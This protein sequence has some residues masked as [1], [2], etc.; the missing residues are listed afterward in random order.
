MGLEKTCE[1]RHGGKV[2]TAQAHLEPAELVLR[3]ALKLKIPAGDI[4]SAE[5]RAGVLHVKWRGGVVDL[6]LGRDAEK[7]ALKIRYPRGRLDKLGIKPQMRV[8][9][10]GL[11]DAEFLAE[12]RERTSDVKVGRPAKDTD[13]ILVALAKSAD[14]PKLKTLRASLKK[15]GMIWAVWTKGRKE[16][17]EDDVRAYGPVAGL[18]DVKVMS[19]SDTLSGLKLVIPL[20]D[21]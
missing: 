1:V 20:K 19:F 7:W 13:A 6:V 21:R 9:V 16:F 2:V 3:G 14:L 15:N 17:R 12:L 8:A 18:V 4:Q 5:A 10:V 11:D